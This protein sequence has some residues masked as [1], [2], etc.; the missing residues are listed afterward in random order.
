MYLPSLLLMYLPSLLHEGC[1]SS[2]QCCATWPNEPH[3][4]NPGPTYKQKHKRHTNKTR[5]AVNKHVDGG[6]KLSMGAFRKCFH[7]AVGSASRLVLQFS[8]LAT[9][10]V[11]VSTHDFSTSHVK[12]TNKCKTGQA[13]GR[14][15]CKEFLACC[16]GILKHHPK[17]LRMVLGVTC[18]Y[19]GVRGH[20]ASSST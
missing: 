20:L 18:T 4:S 17:H 3:A 2:L 16:T 12:T 15:L 7:G 10:V 1:N 19:N 6:A 5:Q 13:S 8:S 11:Y 9:L 14:T